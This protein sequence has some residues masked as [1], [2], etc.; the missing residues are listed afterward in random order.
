VRERPKPGTVGRAA[1]AA[2]TTS[3]RVLVLSALLALMLLTGCATVPG[4]CEP[5]PEPEWSRF[6]A[7][8]GVVAWVGARVALE[9]AVCACRR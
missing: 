4:S 5:G 7:A 1:R 9:I 6:A 2:M 8:V 3:R